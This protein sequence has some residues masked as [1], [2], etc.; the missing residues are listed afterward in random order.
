MDLP[1]FTDRVMAALN[2]VNEIKVLGF[3]LLLR[4]SQLSPASVIPRLDDA[5][6]SIKIVMKDVEVKEDTVKQDLER[7]GTQHDRP[8]KLTVRGDAAIG[9]AYCCTFVQ[10]VCSRSG[11][12]VPR[13]RFELV[14]QTRM[15]RVSRLFRLRD[16]TEV[17][18]ARVNV[19]RIMHMPATSDR[20]IGT[21]V[22]M[23]MI[24][25]HCSSS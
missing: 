15:E 20:S 8:R 14:S 22:E 1:T 17:V 24:I 13:I 21:R 6:E 7:K 19:I 16:D 9:V 23:Y 11:T 3:M 12:R 25:M 5:T 2:D 4:L 10:N 18:R